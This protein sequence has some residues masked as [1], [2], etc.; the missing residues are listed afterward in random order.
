MSATGDFW[1]RNFAFFASRQMAAKFA[2]VKLSRR[3]NRRE[4]VDRWCFVECS[5][6]PKSAFYYWALRGQKQLVD[7][8]IFGQGLKAIWGLR[9][10]FH[11]AA[12]A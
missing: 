8:T 6:F 12:A 9:A 1:R 10:W 3:A 5:E 7:M 4:P 2:K 11:I